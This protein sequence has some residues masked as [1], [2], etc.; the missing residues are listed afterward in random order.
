MRDSAF[1]KASRRAPGFPAALVVLSMRKD[2]A[3]LD[4]L[5]QIYKSGI[6]Q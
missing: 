1:Q 5:V 2:V 4:F 3:N 6:A